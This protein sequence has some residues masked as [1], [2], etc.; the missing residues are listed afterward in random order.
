LFKLFTE[1]AVQYHETEVNDN[2]LKVRI[3]V[4]ICSGDINNP[5]HV[6]NIVLQVKPEIPY[7]WN[8]VINILR[9][10]QWKGKH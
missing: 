5:R 1:L 7:I 8:T 10:G 4:V 2:N 9:K 3:I 6:L